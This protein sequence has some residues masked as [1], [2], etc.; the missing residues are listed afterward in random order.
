MSMR[1]IDSP[2]VLVNVIDELKYRLKCRT[3]HEYP[4]LESFDAALNKF[5]VWWEL[6]GDQHSF[7][8]L[9]EGFN[10]TVN[11]GKQKE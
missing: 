8:T 2:E 5:I 3:V 11:A 7:A 4:M 1:N 10:A 9:P 6:D